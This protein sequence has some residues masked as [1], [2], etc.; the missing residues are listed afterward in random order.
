MEYTFGKKS[1]IFWYIT[2]MFNF[3]VVTIIHLCYLY[4]IKLHD[5]YA[6][7]VSVK[8]VKVSQMH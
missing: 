2:E 1:L 5:R 3:I 4:Q 7:K 8:T 6:N